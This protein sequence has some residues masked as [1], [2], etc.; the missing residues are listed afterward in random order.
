MRFFAR[1]RRIFLTY[2]V[3][4]SVSWVVLTVLKEITCAAHPLSCES[5]LREFVD[6]FVRM[7]GISD[8]ACTVYLLAYSSFVP[9]I[10]MKP[11]AGY[12]RGYTVRFEKRP[13]GWLMLRRDGQAV[14]IPEE[15]HHE[16]ESLQ[17]CLRREIE[18]Y[19]DLNESG[20]VS[21]INSIDTLKHVISM[22]Y[23]IRPLVRFIRLPMTEALGHALTRSHQSLLIGMDR[24]GY[25]AMLEWKKEGARHNCIVIKRKGAS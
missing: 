25:E 4:S 5:D 24:T 6:L 8:L 18:R 19:H 13:S 23:Q 15:C 20:M 16:S 17:N 7:L 12:L 10:A 9:S 14:F 2:S 1:T 11:Y 21:P 22:I 3:L